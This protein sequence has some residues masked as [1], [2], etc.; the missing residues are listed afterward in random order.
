VVHDA[1]TT[2]HEAALQQSIRKILHILGYQVE[3]LENSNEFTECCGYGGLML[4]ANKEIAHKMIKKRS[5]QSEN[6]FLTYCAM[7]R[8]NFASQGKQSYHL[9]DLIFPTRQQDVAGK[10]G[11]GYSERQENRARLKRTLQKEVWGELADKEQYNVKLIISENVRQTLEELMILDSDIIAV[12]SQA[13]HTGNKFKNMENNSYIASFKPASVTYWVE[14]SPQE[15]GFLVHN[16]Y[17]H[18]LEIKGS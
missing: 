1:C 11:P 3:E 6:D 14:Y 2:R 16:A 12:I 4:F 7:C 5:Q 10:K 8:D 13:E 17:S 18:R 15:D 9:L